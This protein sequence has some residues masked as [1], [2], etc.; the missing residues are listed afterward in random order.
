MKGT[1][2]GNRL[3]GGT[4]V[5]KLWEPRCRGDPDTLLCHSISCVEHDTIN[6][7]CHFKFWFALLSRVQS[8]QFSTFLVC[9]K[10]MDGFSPSIYILL[11]YDWTCKNV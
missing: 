4:Q 5:K 6:F 10:A 11:R 1:I 2:Y 8:V 7:T 9:L 3:P